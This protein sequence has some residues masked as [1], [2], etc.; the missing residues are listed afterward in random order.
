MLDRRDQV[1]ATQLAIFYIRCL[2]I[3]YRNVFEVFPMAAAPHGVLCQRGTLERPRARYE[4][5]L[6]GR[7]RRFRTAC[8]G[9]TLVP[10]MPT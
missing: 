4:T 3:T 8:Q 7:S 10:C 5:A 9:R 6:I 1:R 2:W